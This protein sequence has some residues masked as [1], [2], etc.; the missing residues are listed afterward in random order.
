M[1]RRLVVAAIITDEQDRVLAARRNRPA[2]L[3]GRW[4]FPGGKL[5]SGESPQQAVVREIREELG[6]DVSCGAELP[7]E[8]GCW[9]IDEHLE[10]R[11]FFARITAGSPQPGD[12]HDE[13]CWLEASRLTELDWLDADVPIAA[14][15]A[16]V[17][18]RPQL[19]WGEA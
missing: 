15:A 6:T 16:E 3:A 9:P 10:L 13:L 12:S 4:E 14:A 1:S 11:A 18:R 8:Q 7:A 17:L 19:L 5:E 2:T